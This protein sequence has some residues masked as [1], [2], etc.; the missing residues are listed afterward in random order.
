MLAPSRLGPFLAALITNIAGFSLGQGFR[1]TQL[2][3]GEGAHF[4]LCFEPNLHQAK[5]DF[6]TNAATKKVHLAMLVPN[7]GTV[8]RILPLA[9]PSRSESFKWIAAAPMAAL[10]MFSLAGDRMHLSRPGVAVDF[11]PAP[12]FGR[13]APTTT[14][15][16]FSTFAT[17][18]SPFCA[19]HY[20]DVAG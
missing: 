20:A 19:A 5:N 10:V 11:P 18:A 17:P 13:R 6:A 9:K 16:D 12:C 4:I 3:R 15:F 8:S 14:T 2:F 1:Y 7:L